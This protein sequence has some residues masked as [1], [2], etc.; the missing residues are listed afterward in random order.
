MS[1]YG[2]EYRLITLNSITNNTTAMLPISELTL[3][4]QVGLYRIEIKPLFDVNAT[5]TGVGFNLQGGSAVLSNYTFDS[6]LTSTS[7]SEFNNNY[8]SR[9]QDFTTTQNSRLTDNRCSI[10]AEF[11]VTTSGTVIPHF[12]S[13]VAG[14]L[15][16]LKPDS[17]LIVQKIK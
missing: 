3:N 13:E 11:R 4:L 16:T 8:S 5:T 15:V 2:E 7:T 9:N 10:V 12:R 1:Y 6:E 14:G 17:Y